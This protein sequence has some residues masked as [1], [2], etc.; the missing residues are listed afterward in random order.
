LCA[1]WHPTSVIHAD[2]F[3]EEN[4]YTAFSLLNI[5]LEN[6]SFIEDWWWFTGFTDWTWW[7]SIATLNNQMV[8]WFNMDPREISMLTNHV[9]TRW[10]CFHVASGTIG[11]NVNQFGICPRQHGEDWW[12]I[13]AHEIKHT[14]AIC[15]H[16]LQITILT[17]PNLETVSIHARNSALLYVYVVDLIRCR[18]GLRWVYI[19]QSKV[20][21][22]GIVCL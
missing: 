3:P 15:Q 8:R 22:M 14:D 2:P 6:G 17:N 16:W 13:F 19:C 10:W 21:T 5:A 1:E 20:V 18:C 4:D 9:H 11:K 7:L 12:R